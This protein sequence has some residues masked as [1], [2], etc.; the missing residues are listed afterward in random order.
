MYL[1]ASILLNEHWQVK[2]SW[3]CKAEMK[4]EML[5]PKI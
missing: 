4:L 5:F 2:E 1:S 3:V